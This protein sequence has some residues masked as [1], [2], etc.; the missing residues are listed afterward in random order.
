MR[1]DIWHNCRTHHTVGVNT[2]LGSPRSWVNR[3]LGLRKQEPD[4]HDTSMTPKSVSLAGIWPKGVSLPDTGRYHAL[5]RFFELPQDLRYI[6]NGL[7]RDMRL[8]IGIALALPG[9][10][11]FEWSKEWAKSAEWLWW[12]WPQPQRKSQV[13][14][15]LDHEHLYKLFDAGLTHNQVARQENLITASVKYVWDK[16]AAGKPPQTKPRV[17]KDHDE[18]IRRLQAG[19]AVS[20]I[21]HDHSTSAAWIYKIK[22]RH[23]I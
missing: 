14:S 2:V 16:W 17:F 15:G 23:G 11:V 7:G 20:R 4:L 19:D 1:P 8:V 13:H 9:D 22:N 18:I 5:Y 12:S 3:S 10:K 21:A 6:N